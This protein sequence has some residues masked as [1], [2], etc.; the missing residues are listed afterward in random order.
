MSEIWVAAATTVVG[1]YIAG[2][3]AE[4]QA[5]DQQNHD[6]QMTREGARWNAE[7]SSFEAEQEDYYSQLNRQRKQRGLENFRQFSSMGTF[8]P[9]YQQATDT[10]ITLPDKPN[11]EE[12]F[13]EPEQPAQQGGGGRS[14]MERIIDPLGLF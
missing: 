8:A 14:T 12:R 13:K 10:T 3:G 1:G 11:A 9:Q 7:L 4:E 6:R 5:E 2:Q